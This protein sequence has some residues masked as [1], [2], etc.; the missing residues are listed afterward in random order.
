MAIIAA[1]KVNGMTP[2]EYADKLDRERLEKLRAMPSAAEQLGTIYRQINDA[3]V[4][5]AE[6]FARGWNG[7]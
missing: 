3:F 1:A 5:F 7:R 4:E 6:N 2:K